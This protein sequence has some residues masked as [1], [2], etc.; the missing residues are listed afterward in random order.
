MRRLD[1]RVGLKVFRLDRAQAGAA[2]PPEAHPL[3]F[4]FDHK[5]QPIVRKVA[6]ILL[7]AASGSTLAFVA[8]KPLPFSIG[9]R[10]GSRSLIRGASWY[11]ES[12]SLSLTARYNNRPGFRN[13]KV[14][15]RCAKDP[16]RTA[17]SDD[18]SMGIKPAEL[19]ARPDAPQPK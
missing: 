18:A 9:S 19:A 11:S 1:S 6:F 13:F 2:R 14:G 10:P 7:G 3:T 4:F 15:F 16:D 5:S 12:G 8:T 17:L